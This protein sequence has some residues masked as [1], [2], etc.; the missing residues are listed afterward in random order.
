MINEVGNF[1]VGGANSIKGV[2]APN[3]SYGSGKIPE[4]EPDTVEISGKEKK[5][6]SAGK[7]IGA[8]LGLTTLAVG[9]L[10]YIK[11]KPLEGEEKAFLKRMQDGFG[12][13]V[14]GVKGFFGKKDWA[15]M[16]EEERQAFVKKDVMSA[17]EDF[18]CNRKGLE[19]VKAS[20]GDKLE[21]V[22]GTDIEA[23][24]LPSGYSAGK[25]TENGTKFFEKD[26]E[27]ALVQMSTK[28]GK[29]VY[30][31]VK[32]ADNELVMKS[33]YGEATY[34]FESLAFKKAYNVNV[35]PG[36]GIEYKSIIQDIDGTVNAQY[37]EP[38]SKTLS[39]IE[40]K[41]EPEVL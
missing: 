29:D 6:S 19:N 9:I 37:Y 17:I 40:I 18:N 1:S 22:K 3:I 13:V 36:D 25:L 26:G 30:S 15:K 41:I 12:E 32:N 31:F 7:I 20:I 5:K 35:Q 21:N 27:I 24:D 14:S 2:T 33:S 11:G 39:S 4:C 16:T 23:K 8:I 38:N 10:S 28:D 34:D